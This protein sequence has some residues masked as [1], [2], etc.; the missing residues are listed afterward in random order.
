MRPAFFGRMMMLQG[1]TGVISILLGRLASD[2]P[3]NAD[4]INNMRRLV[5]RYC[6][7]QQVQCHLSH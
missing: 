1:D 7:Q 5:A 4:R 2:H 3:V 6:Q